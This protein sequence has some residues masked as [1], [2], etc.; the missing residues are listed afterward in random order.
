MKTTIPFIIKF[1]LIFSAF[2]NGHLLSAENNTSSQKVI[3]IGGGIAG[4]S[5]ARKLHDEG[6]EVLILEAR[7]RIGGRIHTINLG[8][9]PVDLGATWLNGERNNPVAEAASKYQIKKVSLPDETPKLTFD[10]FSESTFSSNIIDNYSDNFFR[11]LRKLKRK[12]GASASMSEAAD[13][14]IASHNL[15]GDAARHARWAIEQF[16]VELF[17]AGPATKT[18]LKWFDEDEDFEGKDFGFPDGYA[19]VVDAMASGLNIEYNRPVKKIDYSNPE[20]IKVD[21]DGQI[22]KGSRVII[23]VP[24]GVLKAG[25]I[26]FIPS[27]PNKKLE[28]INRLEM[29]TLEKVILQFDHVFWPKGG[30]IYIDEPQGRL[31]LYLDI[32]AISHNPTLVVFYGGEQS[33][34]IL[35]RY[36]DHSIQKLVLDRLSQ[37]LNKEI[38][39]PIAYH[40][41]RW[42]QDPFTL[43]SYSFIPVGSSPRD[44]KE[45]AKPVDERMFFAGEACSPDYYG[46]THGAM[47]SGLKAAKSILKSNM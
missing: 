38:P 5:A 2:F 42:G 35:G 7:D 9:E 47:I 13:A 31:P 29:G 24:L 17:Y 21:A 43:G 44:M 16:N 30:L 45:L 33:V 27:L 28:A 11:K 20:E 37:A 40:V 32:S 19:Q 1:S 41:T 46:Q 26:D 36:D 4:I 23:T 25:H 3:V 6:Q 15:V 8:G 22:Y 18:S 34:S 39:E 14:Y 10:S 12:L